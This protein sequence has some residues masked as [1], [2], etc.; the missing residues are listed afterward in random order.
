M[1]PL[2]PREGISATRLRAPGGRQ[3]HALAEA[4]VPDS[5][6]AWLRGAFPEA[7]DSDLLDLVTEG[8]LSTSAGDGVDL[9]DPVIPGEFY[10]FHRPVP[11]EERVPFEIGIVHE[12]SELLVVDK[13]HFLASTP[14]GRFVREC[15]VTRLRVERDEP[16]LVAIHRLDRVTAGLLVLSRRP[17]TRG[18]YQRL[19]QDRLIT[20]TYRALAELPAKGPGTA[21]SG[22]EYPFEYAS[23]LE[24]TKGE[25]QVREVPGAPNAVTWIDLVRRF[26]LRGGGGEW[27]G[28]AGERCGDS[29]AQQHGGPR[30][31]GEF[32][33][34]PLTGKTHQLRAQLNALGM[35]I[36]GD[37]VYPI[38]VAP[39]PYDF[40]SPLQLLAA[41]LEFRD[42]LTG[43]L[44]EFETGLRLA[45]DA[46]RA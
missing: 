23:R 6:G 19:F 2:A 41:R 13:P 27:W 20:K 11:P 42:P 1:S 17:A 26:R 35:P 18:I 5:V 10:W 30:S 43:E 46:E 24:K 4:P 28:A 29:A 40:S 36:L 16:D 7:T 32:E 33:L 34:R 15:A 37:P 44:R 21:A 45:A 8:Q 9:T 3:T 25:R 14:N 38:D 12:D 39:D 22:R 31:I